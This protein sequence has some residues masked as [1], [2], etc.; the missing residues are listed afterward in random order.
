[1]E[2]NVLGTYLGTHKDWRLGFVTLRKDGTFIDE[3]GNPRGKW[4]IQDHQLA[5][6]WDGYPA[7]R[8]FPHDG[9]K[10]WSS[11][12]KKFVLVKE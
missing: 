11:R 12:E 8:L 9:G 4:E 2:S 1:M 6:S 3:R 7:E 5:M 10:I